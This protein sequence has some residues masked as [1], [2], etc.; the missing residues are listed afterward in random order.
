M[1]KEEFI[2]QQADSE[3]RIKLRV[4]PV[5]IIYSIR[6][7]VAFGALVLPIPLFL[8]FNTEARTTILYVL[9]SCIMVFAM[10]FP[11][12]RYSK[13][14]FVELA[15]KCPSCQSPL[16]FLF[17]LKTNET[18]ICYSCGKKIFE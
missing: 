18:G 14:R 5:G 8:Y 16:V 3:R 11:W 12:E 6:I 15:I 2:T 4:M 7:A 10:T 1:T 13:R 17:D 9:G